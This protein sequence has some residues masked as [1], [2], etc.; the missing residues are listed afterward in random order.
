MDWKFGIAC[1]MAGVGASIGFDFC[2]LRP[3]CSVIVRGFH[4]NLQILDSLSFLPLGLGTE[5][6][7][8]ALSTTLPAR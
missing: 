1:R 3:L 7:E 6:L 4:T 5:F 2:V 8:Q